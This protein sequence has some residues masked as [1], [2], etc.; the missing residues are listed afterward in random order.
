MAGGKDQVMSYQN[1][2]E[3]IVLIIQVILFVMK[4]IR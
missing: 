4:F 1:M 3:L 2:M